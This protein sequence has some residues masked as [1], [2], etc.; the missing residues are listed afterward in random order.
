MDKTLAITAIALV[1]VIMVMGA[2]A[3]AMAQPPAD[4]LADPPTDPP[5]DTEGCAAT[6]AAF[7]AGKMPKDVW[8]KIVKGKTC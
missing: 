8:V 2:A 5:A 6:K 7:Q 4:P 1:A 3:P